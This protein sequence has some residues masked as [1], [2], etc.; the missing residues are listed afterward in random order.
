MPTAAHPPKCTAW[1]AEVDRLM[2]RD[3]CIDHADA[4]WS[5][6]DTL[7]YWRYGDSPETFVEWYTEKY[8]LIRFERTYP[9][10]H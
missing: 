7:R 5:Q 1:V 6:E 10:R 9:D 3:W 4:G 8:G 2:K